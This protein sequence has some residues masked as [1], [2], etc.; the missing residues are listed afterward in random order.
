MTAPLT[1]SA[2]A[3]MCAHRCGRFVYRVVSEA[4]MAQPAANARSAPPTTRASDADGST[5]NVVTAAARVPA[6]MD[7]TV[8]RPNEPVAG[9]VVGVATGVGL[10]VEVLMVVV[11]FLAVR[12]GRPHAP[13]SR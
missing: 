9:A 7:A 6:A 5:T 2:A 10:A 4:N 3:G 13:R 12:G 11:P 1:A 8:M